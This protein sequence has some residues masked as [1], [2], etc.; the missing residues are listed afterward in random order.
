MITLLFTPLFTLACLH[1][2]LS[3]DVMLNLSAPGT[4]LVSSQRWLGL[5]RLHQFARLGRFAVLG[6]GA[7]IGFRLLWSG[8]AITSIQYTQPTPLP[9]SRCNAQ[10][11]LARIEIVLGPPAFAVARVCIGL[12]GGRGLRLGRVDVLCTVLD[13]LSLR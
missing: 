3:A 9:L 10:T 13:S 5:C 1:V 11:S 8:A 12:K 2:R 7:F 6:L 4:A